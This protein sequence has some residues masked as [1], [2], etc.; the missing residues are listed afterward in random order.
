MEA[1]RLQQRTTPEELL[2]LTTAERERIRTIPSLHIP[3]EQTIIALLN[4]PEIRKWMKQERSTTLLA[5][6]ASAAEVDAATRATHSILSRWLQ[7]LHDHLLHKGEWEAK[8]IEEWRA[9]VDDILL[10]WCA[11][12]G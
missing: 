11:E 2:H 7:S 6:A 1:L 10:H 9:A 4:G 8:E 3:C 5:A 12:T